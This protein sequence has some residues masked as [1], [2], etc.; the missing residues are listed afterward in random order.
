[1]NQYEVELEV[2]GPTAMWTR[3]D[4]GDAPVSYPAPT[5][6]AAKGVFE[7][8]LLSEW[9]DVVPTSRYFTTHTR[10]I[11]A[12]RYGRARSWPRGAAISCSRLC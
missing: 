12:A 8:I 5:F 4:T 6:G 10:R 3:P 9:A 2:S 7:S 1:M 11:T